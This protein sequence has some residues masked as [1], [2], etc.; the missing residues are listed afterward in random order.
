MMNSVINMMNSVLKMMN[1][2]L[3]MMNSVL[4]VMNSVINVYAFMMA[5]QL[6]ALN[7]LYEI[8]HF[9]PILD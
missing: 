3:Q 9:G 2:V 6:A 1:S 7:G 4:Q 8:H 5:D